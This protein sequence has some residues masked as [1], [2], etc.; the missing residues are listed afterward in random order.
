MT[1]IAST[2]SSMC[3]YLLQQY[4]T[5]NQFKKIFGEFAFMTFCRKEKNLQTIKKFD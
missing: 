4:N 5:Y 1:K 2:N 3:V